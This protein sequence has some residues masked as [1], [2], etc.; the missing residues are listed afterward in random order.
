M[1]S[2][3]ALVL[4]PLVVPN[5]DLE[6][7]NADAVWNVTAADLVGYLGLAA[8][9]QSN[10]DFYSF[11]G[12]AGT[13]INFQAMS[14]VLTRAA[15]PFDA[16]LAI[17][18]SEGQVIASNDDSF[19]DPDS[20]IIDFTLPYSGT[21]YAM[22]TSSPK[23]VALHE[24]LT[25]DYE[26]LIYTFG[27]GSSRSLSALDIETP[28]PQSSSL[29]DSIYAGSA[30]DTMIAGAGDDTIAGAQP[31]DLIIFGSGTVTQLARAPYLNV[32]A[33]AAQTVVSEGE[34]ITFTGSYL[35]PDD[36]DAHTYAW[37]VTAPTGQT[38]ATGT[39]ASFTF[40]P[41]DAGTYDV[42]YTVSDRN[43]G[44]GSAD[45]QITSNAIEPT[46]TSPTTTQNAVE[47]N[48]TPFDLGSLDA[49]G[50]GPFTVTVRWG[51][52]QSSTFSPSGSGDLTYAHA[53]SRE[54]SYTISETVANTAD[55]TSAATTFPEP[56]VVVDQPVVLTAVPVSATIGV[57]TGPVLVATFVDPEGADPV[58]AYSASV[59]WGDP[60]ISPG[61][62]SYDSTSGVFSVYA[63]LSFDQAGPESITVTI[64]HGNA[65]A[66]TTIAAASV[67]R[68]VSSIVLAAPASVVYGQSATFTATV[69]GYGTPT[70]SVTF[71]AGEI[72]SADQLGTAT[73][74]VA[75][76]HD[77][78]SVSVSNLAAS[79]SPYTII[80]V[81][82]DDT[83]NLGSTSNSVSQI[84]TPA[85]LT[86]TA[87]SATK[88]YGQTVTFASTAF[89]ETGL[90]NNDSVTG[91]TLT[92][93][94]AAAGGDRRWLALCDR[95]KFCSRLRTRQLHDRLRE[96]RDGRHTRIANH[97]R[98]EP[99]QSLWPDRHPRRHR[100]HRNRPG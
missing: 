7:T 97:H 33:T 59:V 56:V 86:I 47:G 28:T 48:S 40:S 1:A 96:R 81:Y 25:G 20:T 94:G 88:V 55:G 32:V 64:S 21:Y 35:D 68:A 23:S 14:V 43:N 17:Y 58:S 78:A 89:T 9:G 38:V 63:S 67:S 31:Q 79:N 29:G 36:A 65:S 18:N 77:Q 98:Q 41:G 92:S 42:T 30:D 4:A 3:Q 19:Q 39:G 93:A 71:Y 73:L 51:D 69:T 24:P 76:S 34:P 60:N 13:L 57:A 82:N 50:T 62:I 5:T 85:L 91:V 49:S 45:V 10:T 15:G 46:L 6:G 87:K 11:T 84:V 22:V 100:L 54:G 16:Y 95:G 72:N 66:S 74:S 90:M 83:N 44:S 2:A 70:G 61:T 37:V 8:P 27:T 26:L 12:Q 99:D 52:G 75:G 80:A 53:Y